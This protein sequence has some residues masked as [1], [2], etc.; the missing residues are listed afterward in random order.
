M[1]KNVK[2]NIRIPDGFCDGCCYNNNPKPEFNCNKI[3]CCYLVKHECILV[4]G[5]VI[6]KY[7]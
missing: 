5:Y 7:D 3:K 4:D 6:Y 2:D 1:V